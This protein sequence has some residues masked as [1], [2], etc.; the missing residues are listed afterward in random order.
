MER[1]QNWFVTNPQHVFVK[2]RVIYFLRLRNFF[3][4]FSVLISSISSI[5]SAIQPNAFSSTSFRYRSAKESDLQDISSLLQETF[6]DP[7]TL[8]PPWWKTLP[9]SRA[10]SQ[11]YQKLKQRWTDMVQNAN[12]PHTWIIA[13]TTVNSEIAGFMELGSMPVPVPMPIPIAKPAMIFT[14]EEI[15]EGKA[16]TSDWYGVSVTPIADSIPSTFRPERPFLANLAVAKEYRRQGIA[17]TLVKLALKISKK[18]LDDGTDAQDE[19]SSW[20]MYL[21]VEADNEA[22]KRLYDNLDF[23]VVLDETRSLSPKVLHQLRR[24]PRLY[25]EKNI[26]R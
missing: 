23:T 26:F 5:G 10:D 7:L 19:S 14:S 22:A 18:W 25:Y 24:P 16:S 11:N 21:G 12:V 20:S 13:E 17:T 3:F 15:I 6:E 9:L 4:G 1:H 8:P 2:S